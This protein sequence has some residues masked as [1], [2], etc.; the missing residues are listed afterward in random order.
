MSVAS[1]IYGG[2]RSTGLLL[3]DRATPRSSDRVPRFRTPGSNSLLDE[4]GAIREA[5]AQRTPRA[6]HSPISSSPTRSGGRSRTRGLSPGYDASH[7]HR[8]D[9]ARST[10]SQRPMLAGARRRHTPLSALGRLHDLAAVSSAG[11]GAG[12]RAGEA[13]N[14]RR[15]VQGPDGSTEGVLGRALDA[16]PEPVTLLGRREAARPTPWAAA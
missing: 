11:G 10:A 15:R 7:C 2:V 4:A 5:R 8:T 14:S 12:S 16:A 13:K 9:I 6:A 1:R 3:H